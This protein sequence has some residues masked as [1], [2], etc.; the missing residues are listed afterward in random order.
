[1]TDIRQ[2][3]DDFNARYS[4]VWRRYR[5]LIGLIEVADPLTRGYV[6]TPGGAL[7]TDA[8]KVAALPLVGEHDFTSFCRSVEG[9][10]NVRR[11]EE[12]TLETGPT[13]LT[14]WVRAN[15]FCH[16]MVR[17]IVGHL[18]D[19]GRGIC[20]SDFDGGCHR[21]TGPR[22]GRHSGT[23]TWAHPLGGRLLGAPT[24]WPCARGGD[25]M[26]PASFRKPFPPNAPRAFDVR[27]TNSD[28]NQQDLLTKTWRH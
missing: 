14:I 5:Y 1:M 11:L 23:A 17:S 22:R 13:L 12:L 2:A 7:N 27:G 9:K 20:G 18:Y 19:V 4:A 25:S 6:W 28:D 21:E 8:M 24:N 15:A 26:S 16:Q 10:S 3:N